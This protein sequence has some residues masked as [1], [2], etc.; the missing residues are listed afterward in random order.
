[1]SIII[2]G[3]RT[4]N[5][6]AT[7]LGEGPMWHAGRGSCFWVDIL[8]NSIFEYNLDDDRLVRYTGRRMVSLI[9]PVFGD[10]NFLVIGAQGG[11]GIYDLTT[12][13][14]TVA[15]DL[16]IVWEHH[17]CNDGAVDC[18]GNLWVGTTHINH[19]PEGGDLYRVSGNWTEDKKIEKV[20]V[21]NGMCWSPDN[22]T[23]YFIDSPTKEVRAFRCD[24]E[25]G[26]I[27]FDRIVIKVPDGMG[28]PDGM[29]MDA[30]GILWIAF[31]GGGGVGGFD[32][33]TG[34]LEY[35]I[36]LPVPHVSS[37]AFVGPNRDQLLV[38]TAR[39]G[40]SE[41]Q[42]AEF[43]DSGRTYLVAMN[44]PGLETYDCRLPIA[45]QR[46]TDNVKNYE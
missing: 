9:C 46:L 12:H 17:R 42:L 30:K 34:K 13:E 10:D 45:M 28:I 4:L 26:V 19:D 25:T 21:S 44:V 23:M 29:C 37:C 14:I 39:K 43:P 40:L 35:W 41:K 7:I 1:M 33:A 24:A 38:T 36:P 11:V 32:A 20:T 5:A 16:G 3:A 22:R 6:P 27:T 18:Y 31:W 15:S 8:G 2:D